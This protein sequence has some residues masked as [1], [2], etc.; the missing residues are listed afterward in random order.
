M[1]TVTV[2]PSELL[3]SANELKEISDQ[4][5]ATRDNRLGQPIV[6]APGNDCVSELAASNLSDH[7]RTCRRRL[8]DLANRLN[9]YALTLTNSAKEYATTEADNAEGLQLEQSRMASAPQISTQAAITQENEEIPDEPIIGLAGYQRL[10]WN[11]PPEFNSNNIYEGVGVGSL[12]ELLL[13]FRD[14]EAE[15]DVFSNRLQKWENRLREQWSGPA[16]E[17]AATTATELNR[18]MCVFITETAEATDAVA[19]IGQAYERARDGVIP[20][21]A[22][23]DNR[24]QRADLA[25]EQAAG[26][27]RH[28][29]KISELD[30]EY[31]QFWMTDME[32][33]C[34]YERAV[35]IALMRMPVW[36]KLPWRAFGL[37]SV[38]ERGG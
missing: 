36:K 29:K 33:M 26:L 28:D 11:Q 16:A 18:W 8:T 22:I 1:P 37:A 21:K 38:R 9:E 35:G 27:V 20:P 4:I 30:A 7:L 3:Q 5:C 19:T 23:E 32:A 34:W 15:L 12:R 14:V 25:S 6:A 31:D 24:T 17:Q 13:G 2:Q 10:Y